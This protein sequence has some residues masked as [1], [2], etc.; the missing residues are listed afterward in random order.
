MVLVVKPQILILE[1]KYNVQNVVCMAHVQIQLQNVVA[2]ATKYKKEEML[3]IEN[4]VLITNLCLA[5]A[6]YFE[7]LSVYSWTCPMTLNL[8]KLQ[9]CGSLVSSHKTS[10]A[11]T[12][13]SKKGFNHF[14][15][16]FA[17]RAVLH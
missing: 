4:V 2:K 5:G 14:I 9:K 3:W 12:C 6:V 10:F 1:S 16:F 7:L 8:P 13:V 15:F 17:S 11:I